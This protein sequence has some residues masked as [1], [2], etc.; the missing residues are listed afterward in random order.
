MICFRGAVCLVCLTQCR[1]CTGGAD[2]DGSLTHV[3][4][5]G[6]ATSFL[7]GDLNS[8]RPWVNAWTT[9]SGLHDQVCYPS[10]GTLEKLHNFSEPHP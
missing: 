1:G 9:F 6:A 8:K 3:K 2:L 10:L 4:A 5:E 7:Q